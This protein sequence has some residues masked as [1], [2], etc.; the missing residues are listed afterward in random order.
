MLGNRF[1]GVK[2]AERY[3]ILRQTK[4][5]LRAREGGC[6]VS[7]HRAHPPR[8]PGSPAVCTATSSLSSPSRSSCLSVFGSATAAAGEQ[9][10]VL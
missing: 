5:L 7:L 2:P 8:A 9:D 3:L 6:A 1:A 10:P 4:V